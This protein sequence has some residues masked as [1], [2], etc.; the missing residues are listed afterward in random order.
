MKTLMLFLFALVA[1]PCAGQ[2]ASDPAGNWMGIPQEDSATTIELK[3]TKADGDAWKAVC[4]RRNRSAGSDRMMRSSYWR[5]APVQVT[6]ITLKDG[7]LRFSIDALRIEY[8]GRLNADGSSI[9]GSWSV[10]NQAQG[11]LDFTRMSGSGPAT[12]EQLVQM[13]T[14]DQGQPDKKVAEQLYGLEP[15]ERF[16]DATVARCQSML[17][18]PKAKQ[19]LMA[20]H[21]KS[22]FLDPAAK[23]IPN[24]AAPD[25]EA[26]RKILAATVDYVSETMHRLP[27][28][29]A[30]RTTTTFMQRLWTWDPLQPTGTLVATVLYRDGEEQQRLKSK[31]LTTMGLTTNGEF[32]P[33]LDTVLLDAA[34]G[35]LAW[36][37]WEKGTHGLAA[38][39]RYAVT[40]SK[41]HYRVNG[42]GAGYEGELAIDPT[43]GAVMRVMLLA[44][45]TTAN[46]L[47]DADILVEYGPIQL[48]DRT[49]ICPVHSVA[50]SQMGEV[51]WLN[52]VVFER[53]HLF[54]SQSRILP[55]VSNVP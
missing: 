28:L 1:L 5:D 16:S 13:L 48:G 43:S 34:Q 17:P 25:V 6:S 2:R 50:I 39:F 15:M 38:V 20:L 54:R 27:N 29:F 53:Y 19:A 55:T 12:G 35:H 37:R 26:Q 3:I 11:P 52:D 40:A 33:I 44:R 7:V 24:R 14:M 51:Q 32:G 49:Y 22:E 45:R 42:Q 47:E 4:I 23:E 36:S 8:E 30:T 18:G 21:D 9:A 10:G 46:S 31:H 41:S